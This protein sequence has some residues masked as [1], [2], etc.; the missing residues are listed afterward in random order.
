MMFLY[1]EG[2]EI[3]KPFPSENPWG[4]P[5]RLQTALVDGNMS[6]YGDPSF[7][8]NGVRSISQLDGA[9]QVLLDR[10][11]ISVLEAHTTL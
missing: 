11:R 3:V 1:F 10:I 2:L 5:D 7:N 8:Q 4:I 6:T 9:L